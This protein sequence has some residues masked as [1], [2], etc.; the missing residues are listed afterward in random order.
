MRT[1]TDDVISVLETGGL[2]VGDATGS[3]L[4]VPFVVVYPLI[5]DRDGAISDPFSD[6]DKW[7]QT[8]CEGETREQSEWL[9]DKVE[10]LLAAS[11]LVVVELTRTGTIRDDTTGAPSRFKTFVRARIRAYAPSGA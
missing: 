7:F 4:A 2:S 9:A 8:S 6:L 11:A 3:G 5:Q 1:L 10:T